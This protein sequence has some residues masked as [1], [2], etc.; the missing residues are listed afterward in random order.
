MLEKLF[1]VDV[2]AFQ[3]GGNLHHL[4]RV[5][6]AVLVMQ[7]NRVLKEMGSDNAIVM[8]LEQAARSASITDPEYPNT[9]PEVIVSKW[10]DKVC[11]RYKTLNPGILKAT[12]NGS[13]LALVLNQ[14]SDLSIATHAD[15]KVL[16]NKI[17]ENEGRISAQERM[18]SD[19]Y[20][21]IKR[22]TEDK[23]ELQ[24]RVVT[25][26]SPPASPDRKR[27]KKQSQKEESS[28]LL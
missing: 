23:E 3:S 19:M 14:L 1:V 24:Q 28:I 13:N 2:P 8:K 12:D 4:L 22:L 27:R 17:Q 5:F 9:A 20:D 10:S 25:L 15:V 7:H 26:S 11:V 18:M 16:L 6:F 21:Q